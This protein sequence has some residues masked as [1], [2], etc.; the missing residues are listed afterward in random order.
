MAAPPI[1]AV[2][3]DE[4]WNCRERWV[5]RWALKNSPIYSLN[6]HWNHPRGLSETSLSG[7]TS[8]NHAVVTP[9]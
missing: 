8:T 3:P 9:N 4:G 7:V 5:A 1:G 6:T 2:I